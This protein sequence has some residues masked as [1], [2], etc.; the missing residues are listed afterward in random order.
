M[1]SNAYDE[2]AQYILP[3]IEAQMDD[4]KEMWPDVK[5]LFIFTVTKQKKPATVWYCLL[6]G[7]DIKPV[8]TNQEEVAKAAVKGKVKTVRIQVEDSDAL[9]LVTGGVTG[10]KAFMTGKVKVK[11]DL[12]L[13]QR[14]EEAVEKMGARELA[15]AFIKENKDMVNKAIKSKL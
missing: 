8:I 10:I 7:K 3:V 13:A 14:L 4:S 12:L 6:Q 9:N 15:I 2:L 1:S 5:G 11:G